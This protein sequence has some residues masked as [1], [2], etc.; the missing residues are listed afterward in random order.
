MLYYTSRRSSQSVVLG[1]VALASAAPTPPELQWWVFH[2]KGVCSIANNDPFVLH[3]SPALKLN[4]VK[5]QV[6]NAL[7][8]CRLDL[9][10]TVFICPLLPARSAGC[11]EGVAYYTH[12]LARP[13]PSLQ[14][15]L[16]SR[17]PRLLIILINE[18]INQDRGLCGEHALFS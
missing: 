7:L 2:T 16:D 4:Y 17:K 6:V 10:R 14:N 13:R 1:R 12:S 5:R 3:T 9:P 11:Q 15:S 8:Y 18:C